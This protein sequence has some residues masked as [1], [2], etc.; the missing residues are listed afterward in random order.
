MLEKQSVRSD[1][2]KG[3]KMT[4]KKAVIAIFFVVLCVANPAYA[5]GNAAPSVN[6]DG[7]YAGLTAG[8][9][10]GKFDTTVR[11]QGTYNYFTEITD[12]TQVGSAGSHQFKDTEAVGSLFWG[13]NRQAG[14]FVYG[15]ES[16]LSL[17]YYKVQYDSPSI[18]FISA[19]AQSFTVSINLKS[20]WAFSARPRVGYVKG[21]SF[22]YISAGPELRRFKY[23]FTYSDRAV[24]N[25]Y[26]TISKDKWAFGW[27]A[28]LGYEHKM[29]H[30]WSLR[31]EYF[32]SQ[33]TDII[34]SK[35]DLKNWADGFTH[36]LDFEARIFRIGVSK[37]F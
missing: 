28:G 13:I 19:P 5:G 3:G 16:D 6:W 24:N 36:E 17:T 11:T 37:A 9:S 26:S 7:P 12:R 31:A 23:D 33:Y 25:E 29:P 2:I 20:D 30:D 10:N 15:F 1:K 4:L 35:S 27:T 21:K 34:H 32:Y 22:F 18:T 8:S 14:S